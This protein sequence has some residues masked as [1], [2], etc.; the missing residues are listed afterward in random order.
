VVGLHPNTVLE[1]VI[2]GDRG[3]RHRGTLYEL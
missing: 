2:R 1:G 3:S